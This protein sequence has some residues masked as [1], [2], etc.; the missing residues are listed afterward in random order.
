MD[1]VACT[2]QEAA[3]EECHHNGWGNHNCGHDEDVGVRCGM[4]QNCIDFSLFLFLRWI[5]NKESI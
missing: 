3:I 4:Q 1:N 5:L 2:G